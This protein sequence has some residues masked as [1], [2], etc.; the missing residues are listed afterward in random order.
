MNKFLCK[1]ILFYKIMREEENEYLTNAMYIIQLYKTKY[2]KLA[3]KNPFPS[4]LY[5]WDSVKPGV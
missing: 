5:T 4:P 2:K 1:S 3:Q